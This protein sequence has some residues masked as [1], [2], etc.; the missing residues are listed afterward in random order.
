M[1]PWWHWIL[2]GDWLKPLLA[3]MNAPP[4][5]IPT[6]WI[7]DCLGAS[8]VGIKME[9]IGLSDIPLPTCSL[10]RTT[11]MLCFLSSFLG[12]IPLSNNSWGLPIAPAEMIIS[13]SLFRVRKACCCP[14]FSS[15]NSTPMV[16]GF[17]CSV[18]E[19]MLL[20]RLLLKWIGIIR[21]RPAL[22]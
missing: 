14:P 2:S 17:L 20:S 13:L 8:L 5:V 11:E 6:V 10:R 15:L 12:P 19:M 7:S 21:A 1:I 9:F 4:S 22:D 3:S 16:L 18:Q